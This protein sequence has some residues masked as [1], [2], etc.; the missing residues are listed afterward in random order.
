M[1]GWMDVLFSFFTIW[2]NVV[3]EGAKRMVYMSPPFH[4]CEDCQLR[5]R[6][7]CEFEIFRADKRNSSP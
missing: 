1:D 7:E 2:N 6:S 4:A 3:R 5:F